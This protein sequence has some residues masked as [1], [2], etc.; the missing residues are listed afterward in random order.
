M[1]ALAGSLVCFTLL[2]AAFSLLERLFPSIRG[3]RLWRRGAGTD[4]IYWVIQPFVF[5]PV[6]QAVTA[7]ALIL[8][9]VLSGVGLDRAALTAW[10][11]QGHGPLGRLPVGA[12]VVLA[13]LVADLAGYWCHRLFHGAALWRF[14]AVHHSSVELDW[15]ASARAHPVNEIAGSAVR[16]LVLVALGLRVEVLAGVLPFFTLYAILLHANVSWTFGPLRYVIAS[17]AFHRWHHT[18]QEEGLD[19]NFAGLLPLWD[20]MFGTFHMPEG[21]APVRF[22]VI[23]E[24][25]PDGFWQQLAWPFRKGAGQPVSPSSR[26]SEIAHAA[27]TLRWL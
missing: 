20:L 19:R 23:G 21:R 12:Q 27:R 7:V 8:L 2:A 24:R 22:G 25:V 9:A 6:T 1:R 13:L 15:L 14:H 4:L 5:K 10:I 16:A 11:A 18:A 3:Q 26:S 17:P